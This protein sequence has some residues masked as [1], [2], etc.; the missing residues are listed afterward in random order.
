VEILVAIVILALITLI[1]ASI[2]GGTSALVSQS[3]TSMRSLD[4]GE[5]VLAQIGLDIS[6]MVLR[7]DVDY[8]FTKNGTDSGSGA[9]DVLSFY[10]RTTG[11]D[12]S[13]NSAL[14]PRPLSVV[15]YQVGTDPNP[16][17][18]S[19]PALQLNYGALQIDGSATGAVPFTPSALNSSGVQTQYLNAALGGDLPLPA[20]ASYATLAREVIRFDY[21]LML[22]VDPGNNTPPRLLTPDVP[23]GLN[24]AS[25]IENI[26]GILV[27]IVV[28]D[29]RSRL[30]FP[31][32]PAGADANLSKLFLNPDA[33]TSGPIKDYLTLWTPL[34][35]PAKL[36]SVGIPAQAIDGIH[37]YQRFYPFPW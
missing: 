7:D 6:R 37:I 8:G 17:D 33:P 2:F 31:T 15:S 35:T 3:N 27:G 12:S 4:A 28:V 18:A 16:A 29:P 1:M 5:A 13:G 11:F 22:K 20:T 9:S 25:P 21:C 23:A 19:N 24:G 30:F 34:L 32:S 14:N 10:A 26:A 36:K